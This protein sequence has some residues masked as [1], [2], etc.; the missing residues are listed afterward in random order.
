MIPVLI[1]AGLI[2]GRWWML[3]LAA[4]VWPAILISRD[5]GTGLH[6]AVVAAA[7]AVANTAAA[8]LAHKGIVKLFPLVRKALQGD[9]TKAEHSSRDQ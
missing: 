8:V 4:I 9:T 7:F 6:F 1:L 2:V 5:L 3:P